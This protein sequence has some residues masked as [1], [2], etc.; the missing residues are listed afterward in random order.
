MFLY[1]ILIISKKH[2]NLTTKKQNAIYILILSNYIP[3]FALLIIRLVIIFYSKNKS[4]IKPN[5]MSIVCILFYII[6]LIGSVNNLSTY[7]I[8]KINVLLN[9]L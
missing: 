8:I 7:E 6:C 1:Y 2:T 5:I 4:I 3:L 9:L